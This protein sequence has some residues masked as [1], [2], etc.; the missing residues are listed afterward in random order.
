MV[1]GIRC[2]LFE[3]LPKHVDLQHVGRPEVGSGAVA[4]RYVPRG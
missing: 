2:T 1:R 4:M 3:G